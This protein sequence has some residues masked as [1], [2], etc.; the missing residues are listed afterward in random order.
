MVDRSDGVTGICWQVSTC[1]IS[2][3]G[4]PTGSAQHQFADGG[5]MQWRPAADH[6]MNMHHPV[7]RDTFNVDHLISLANTEIHGFVEFIT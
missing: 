2:D 1:G 6:L 5:Y 3:A 7:R 4:F